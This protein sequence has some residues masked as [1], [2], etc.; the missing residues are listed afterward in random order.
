VVYNE[1]GVSF[2]SCKYVQRNVRRQWRRAFRIDDGLTASNVHQH[3]AGILERIVGRSHSAMF[4]GTDDLVAHSLFF[5]KY[6][7]TEEA[8]EQLNAT[9]GWYALSKEWWVGQGNHG[10]VFGYQGDCVGS[11]NSDTNKFEF[12]TEELEFLRDSLIE[13]IGD[14]YC[15][16]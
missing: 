14:R 16:D 10:I 15:A 4:S 13:T 11:V 1:L 9:V 3:A 8:L 12:F 7:T 2:N 6:F 5:P